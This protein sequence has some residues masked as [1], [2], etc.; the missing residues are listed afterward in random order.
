[1]SYVTYT[2]VGIEHVGGDMFKEVP[3]GDAIFTKV[4]WLKPI[5]FSPN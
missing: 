4:N 1:M 5:S 2:N 3:Q